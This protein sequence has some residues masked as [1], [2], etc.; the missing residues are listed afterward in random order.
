MPRV[1]VH[2]A[3]HPDE[4][5]GIYRLVHAES[6]EQVVYELG[7]RQMVPH[8]FAQPNPDYVPAPPPMPEDLDP[9]SLSEDELSMYFDDRT[10]EQKQPYIEVE[11]EV[12]GAPEIIERTETV[13]YDHKEIIWDATDEQWKDKSPE[14]I[15]EI[16]K[17]IVSKQIAADA[18]AAKKAAKA[19]SNVKDLGSA[20]D[21][22]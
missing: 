19:K 3:H 2:H 21:T 15:V 14:E 12:E 20:G 5:D 16:Q 9:D 7:E 11:E 10:D 22:L 6:V 1:I 17:G 18:R 13:Y 4:G 8:K